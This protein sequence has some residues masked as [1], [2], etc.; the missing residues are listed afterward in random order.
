LAQD[1]NGNTPILWEYTSALTRAQK[2]SEATP[3]A[4]PEWEADMCIN[5]VIPF[6]L[7]FFLILS[8]AYLDLAVGTK[9]S[10]GGAPP[11]S[12]LTQMQR[13]YLGPFML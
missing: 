12:R 9:G 2:I 11:S 1:A 10:R 6:F 4:L 8:F 5:V 7:T 3:A 13:R